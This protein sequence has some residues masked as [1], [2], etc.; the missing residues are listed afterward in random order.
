[1]REHAR[2]ENV[3]E[4]EDVGIE[5]AEETETRTRFAGGRPPPVG[6]AFADASGTA[7]LAYEEDKNVRE[8]KQ[9]VGQLVESRFAGDYQAAFT[10]YDRDADGAVNKSELVT[11]LA[12]AGV[13]NGLT[14][15]VWASKIIERL[16]ANNDRG[17]QWSEFETVFTVST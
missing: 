9:K 13:G 17:V 3:A 12:D 15:G 2:R 1:M 10:H 8:L 14:R 7:V 16:D 5:T 6:G 4:H 11:L